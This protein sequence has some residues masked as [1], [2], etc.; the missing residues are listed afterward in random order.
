MQMFVNKHANNMKNFR[1]LCRLLPRRYSGITK[2]NANAKTNHMQK[3]KITGII[4]KLCRESDRVSKK[5]RRRLKNGACSMLEVLT[6][7]V[8]RG[9]VQR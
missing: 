7:L 8:E 1:K 4:N 3:I 9:M 6:D 5:R 2:A